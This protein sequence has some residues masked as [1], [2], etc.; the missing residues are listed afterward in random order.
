MDYFFIICNY[1]FSGKVTEH[2]GKR[3]TFVV[4]ASTLLL[5]RNEFTRVPLSEEHR[6]HPLF[7]IAAYD[8]T[9][10]PQLDVPENHLV[11]PPTNLIPSSFNDPVPEKQTKHGILYIQPLPSLEVNRD[12]VNSEVL[13]NVQNPTHFFVKPIINNLQPVMSNVLGLNNQQLMPDDLSRFK[14][15]QAVPDHIF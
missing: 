9:N 11:V 14:V 2:G 10:L 5:P 12:R 6:N 8:F 1:P 4:P 7:K 15:Y 13:G 3:L